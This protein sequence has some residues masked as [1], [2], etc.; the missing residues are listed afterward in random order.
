MWFMGFSKANCKNCYACIRVCPVHAIKVTNEQAQ[1]IKER[2]IVCGK[3]FKVCPQNAKL[4][5]SEKEMV[6]H[7][8]SGRKKVVA[9]IAPSFAAIFGKYSNKL[10]KALKLL[11]F[12][13]VEET[14][15][16]VDPIINEYEKYANMENEETYITSFCPPV[17]N[18]IQKYYKDLCKNII[19]VASPAVFH[20]RALKEKYGKDIRVVF[21]GPCLAKKADGHDEDSIDIVLTFDELEQWLKEENINLEYL[22]EEKFDYVSN[23]KRLLP[24]IGGPTKLI[25]SRNPK[26]N[27]I[28][29]DGINDCM[30]VLEGLRKGKFKNALLEMNSCRHSCINGSGMP[31]DKVS[32]YERKE[33]LKKYA[34]SCSEK[35]NNSIEIKDKLNIS[36]DKEILP[37]EVFMKEPSSKELREILNSMGKYEKYDELNCGSC[38]YHTCKEKAIAVYN[39][40]AEINMC[41]PFMREKAENLTSI[42]FDMT[43]NMIVTID[44]NLDII[45]LNPSAEKFFNISKQKAKGLP[46][47]MFLEAEKFEMVKEDKINI[48]KEKI[49][50][51]SNKTTVIQSIIWLEKNQVM[52]WIADDITKDEE[53]QEKIQGMKIDAINMAQKVINKQM[54]VAQEIASLLG[55]TT[56]ET[57]VTL[58]QLK[59]LIQEDGNK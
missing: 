44:K 47:I 36:V 46:I 41:L 12:D 42:I 14:A 3:C 39:N 48:F 20:A 55:E 28:Q 53:L 57:K 59:N 5:K 54:I 38:G 51:N 50:L 27:I 11:G 13:Y 24:I 1:I 43:P 58:T 49:T 21:I 10:P 22:E 2:C 6:K 56:A 34:K 32:S 29:V 16:T 26:K 15:S 25:E 37:R 33:N 31:Y 17:N 18:I 40:M 9:S 19:P 35:D 7:Y 45:Q 52:L 23:D 4:I 30:K 8:I